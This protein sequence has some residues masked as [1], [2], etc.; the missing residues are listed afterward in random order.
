M[1]RSSGTI[2]FFDD[3]RGFGFVRLDDGG[4]D[5]F[6]HR[7]ALAFRRAEGDGP[8]LNSWGAENDTLSSVY[9]PPPSPLPLPEF[10]RGNG[11]SSTQMLPIIK[12][13]PRTASPG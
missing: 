9:T 8:G 4:E 12:I 10:R 6:I 2:K 13:R 7:T 11:R 3:V 1:T 5:A